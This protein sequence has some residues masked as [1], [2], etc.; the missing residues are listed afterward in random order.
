MCSGEMDLGSVCVV[1]VLRWS[2]CVVVRWSS[3]C[4]GEM[5]GI[6]DGGSV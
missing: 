5:E 6:C 1:S 4:S 3:V 2:V